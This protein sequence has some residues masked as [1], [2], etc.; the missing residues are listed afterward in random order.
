MDKKNS[1]YV[2]TFEDVVI[3][4]REISWTGIKT[5]VSLEETNALTCEKLLEC[6]QMKDQPSEPIVS[7]HYVDGDGNKKDLRDLKISNFI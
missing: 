5:I 3:D 7:G 4:I 1:S 6:I 2:A